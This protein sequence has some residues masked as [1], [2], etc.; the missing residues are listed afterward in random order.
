MALPMA[1]QYLTPTAVSF[2]GLGAVSAAVMSSS[3][4]ILLSSSS[5]FAHNVYKLAFRQT[6][7]F[8]HCIATSNNVD[9]FEIGNM[10]RI[11]S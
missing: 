7:R 4:S 5:M 9:S 6:V 1:L 3:D 2:I 10:F 8:V 11:M